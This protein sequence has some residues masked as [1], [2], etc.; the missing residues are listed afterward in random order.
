[1]KTP[2]ITVRPITMDGGHE[3]NEVFLDN[4]KVPVENL[5][6]KE[7][8]GWDCAKFLL[9]NER[10]GIAGVGTPSAAWSAS[11]SWH[12]ASMAGD[13]PLIEDE[14]FREKIAELEIE[15]KALEMTQLRALSPRIA[16][17]ARPGPKSRSSRSRAREIQQRITE[18]LLEAAGRYARPICPAAM[19]SSAPTS[20]GRPRLRRA[21]GAALFQQAQDLDLR[22]LQ[23]DPAQHHRQD[24][25]GLLRCHPA[26]VAGVHPTACSGACG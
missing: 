3:V 25:A 2:G 8:Q 23:R 10:T 5:I 13:A 12:R 20:P 16:R 17:Q 22:R 6:G 24:G 21:A 18:L 19:P 11:R 14:R 15:L 4:V 26:L 9:A 1:M 7:N